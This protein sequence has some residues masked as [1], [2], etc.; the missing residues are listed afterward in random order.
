M[1]E[2][3]ILKDKLNYYIQFY[4]DLNIKDRNSYNGEF[5]FAPEMDISDKPQSRIKFLEDAKPCDKLYLYIGNT[6]TYIEFIGSSYKTSSLKRNSFILAFLSA[7]K[8]YNSIYISENL[9]PIAV[10]DIKEELNEKDGFISVK[11]F[12][13]GF[14]NKEVI[15][16]Y[17]SRDK[18]S[19]IIRN[20]FCFIT[21]CISYGQLI[22]KLNLN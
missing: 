11:I 10:Y 2:K 17:F 21:Y 6:Y 14:V 19:N 8:H 9:T 4:N 1:V 15:T 7:I 18:N 3:K 12:Y 5:S 20:S 13:G 22:D 16:D